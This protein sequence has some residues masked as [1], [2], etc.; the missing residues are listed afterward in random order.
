MSPMRVTR[1]RVLLLTMVGAVTGCTP[2]PTIRGTPGSAPEPVVP[3]RSPEADNAAGWVE[4]FAL[5]VDALLDSAASWDAKDVHTTWLRAL[6]A[7][8]SAHLSRVV[9]EDP[10]IGGHTVFPVENPTELPPLT[11]TTPEEALA[12]LTAAVT[13]GV[14]VL[15][16]GS[17]ASQ[18]A[19]G[20]LFYASLA[21][22]ARGSLSPTLPPVDSGA[23]PSPFVAADVEDSMAVALSHIWAMVRGIELGL[24]RLPSSEELRATGAERLDGVRELR[25]QLLA[26]IGDNTPAVQVWELP[27]AMTTAAE[28]RAAWAVLET[29]LLG[30]LA[31]VAATAGAD[32]RWMEFMLGQVPWVH[33]WGGRLPHWPGWVASA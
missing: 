7:Q 16:R 21:V 20:R 12:V 4:D 25:N 1:R 26:A 22:A 11:A 29:N 17:E 28:I 31:A 24:G 18:N 14:P 13:D 2:D 10:V 5:L 30:A 33:R 6:R 9:T 15:V 32:T 27:N 23:E 8:S 19:P 3:T